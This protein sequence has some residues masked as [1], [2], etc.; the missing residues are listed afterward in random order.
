M[1]A[2][3]NIGLI[4]IGTVGRGVAHLLEQN[5]PVIAHRSGIDIRLKTVCDLAIDSLESRKPGVTYTKDWRDVTG[6]PEI[7]IVVELIGG[8]EP[9]KSIILTALKNGKSAVTANKKL[10]A[11][12]GTDIFRAA[13]LP[14]APSWASRPRW[15]AAIPPSSPSGPAWWPTT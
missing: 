13:E 2:N 11:E 5:G 1:A 7:D 6:D 8:I 15:R 12:A 9:A 14:P 4:G 10:L 3:V